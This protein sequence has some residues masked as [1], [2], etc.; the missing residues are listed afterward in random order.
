[1]LYTRVP[2]SRFSDFTVSPIFF[3]RVPLMKPRTL[4]AC[5]DAASMISARLAP[6]ARRSRP[7][8][9]AVLRPSRAPSAEGSAAV[10]ALAAF[11]AGF[12]VF[13]AALC[14]ATPAL[15]GLLGAPFLRMAFF[16]AGG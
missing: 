9:I 5:Q 11:L 2:S 13:V 15:F 3:P 8:M 4:W 7:R 14:L 10:A 1:M 12:W 6:L 16:F